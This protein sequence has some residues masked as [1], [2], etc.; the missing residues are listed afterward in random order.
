[1]VNSLHASLTATGIE[2]YMN[3]RST[4]STSPD[5]SQPRNTECH[6]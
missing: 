6:N 1:M 3:I 2:I 5:Y 4:V